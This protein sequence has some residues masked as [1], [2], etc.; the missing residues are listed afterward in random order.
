MAWRV[1]ELPRL[2]ALQIQLEDARS[3]R[4]SAARLAKNAVPNRLA[5]VLAQGKVASPPPSSTVNERI[6]GKITSKL[7]SLNVKPNLDAL[8]QA[9]EAQRSELEQ[10]LEE[11]RTQL[12]DERIAKEILQ[13]VIVGGSKT[14]LSSK[15]EAT[16]AE[17]NTSSSIDD[18]AK[19]P[20]IGESDPIMQLEVMRR[21]YADLRHTSHKVIEER[22]SLRRA[23]IA[24]RMV[25]PELTK[26][27]GV[28]VNDG[29]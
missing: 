25:A 20:N 8:Q 14:S 17:S 24:V 26:A 23:L 12:D 10:Q 3:G 7:T 9:W 11:L 16:I 6:G 28:S 29:H 2:E 19:H 21:Q 27:L 1:S 15:H 22:D 13:E 4:E 5:I 18:N